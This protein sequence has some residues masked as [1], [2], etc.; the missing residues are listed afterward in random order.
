MLVKSFVVVVSGVTAGGK[1][2]LIN[3]LHKEFI[4]SK[5]I[6][7]DDYSIDALPSAPP[8]ETPIQDAGNQYDLNLLMKDFLSAK[9]KFPFIF[10]DFPFGYKH[11]A[12]KPYITKAV[13]L[14]TP[15]DVAF[16]RQ[17]I[18]DYSDKSVEEILIWAQTYVDSARQI[19]IDYDAFV[20][21][22]VDL[23]I[24]G[25]LPLIEQLNSIKKVMQVTN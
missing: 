24:D 4:D 9:D 8:I 23:I 17:L 20:S 25:T 21:E 13:Y 11:K 15:L 18:R 7:F 6:S 3:E 12:L 19:F 14:K 5:V 2:T 22:D 16:A 1:T 10:V